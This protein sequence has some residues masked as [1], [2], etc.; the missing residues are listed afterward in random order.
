M[1]ISHVGSELTLMVV[2]E[3]R[4]LTGIENFLQNTSLIELHK[5]ESE[6]AEINKQLI[7]SGFC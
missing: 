3:S 2:T 5:L 6:G 1:S 4:E 7:L